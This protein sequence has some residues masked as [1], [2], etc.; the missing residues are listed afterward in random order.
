MG[1]SRLVWTRGV[2]GGSREGILGLRS[3]RVGLVRAEGGGL[4]MWLMKKGW[5]GG[6]VVPG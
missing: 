1:G 5:E 4:D 6:T 3:C 2:M